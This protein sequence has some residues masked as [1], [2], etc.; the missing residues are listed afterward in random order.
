VIVICYKYKVILEK[1]NLMDR[2]SSSLDYLGLDGSSSGGHDNQRGSNEEKGTLSP[3]REQDIYLPIANVARIMKYSVPQNGK[4]A[5]DAKECVQECVS[6]FISFITSEASE[7]CA[8]EKRK[9]INGEDV[10]YAM[11]NLGFDPY[12]EPL[13]VYLQK[14][15]DSL[16]ADKTGDGGSSMYEDNSNNVS[17]HHHYPPD[18]DHDLEDHFNNHHDHDQFAT[19]LV[20][21]TSSNNSSSSV[22]QLND[23]NR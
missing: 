23:F 1:E 20:N 13:K 12:I 2:S 8:Q 7:R 22:H 17:S 15:R 3:F 21:T 9:T 18:A 19:M 6:E 14:Y 4:I 10:L 5:K 16:K 11:A